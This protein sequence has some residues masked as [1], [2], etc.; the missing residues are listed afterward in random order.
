MDRIYF[1]KKDRKTYPSKTIV[2][3][4]VVTA[5][6][7]T[8]LCLI[9]RWYFFLGKLHANSSTWIL[10]HFL[11]SGDMSLHHHQC[12]MTN[13][14]FGR[15]LLC[16]NVMCLMRQTSNRLHVWKHEKKVLYKK[17]SLSR[18]LNFGIWRQ[19]VFFPKKCRDNWVLKVLGRRE[20]RLPAIRLLADVIFNSQLSQCLKGIL[21]LQFWCAF[22]GCVLNLKFDALKN[23][24]Q[25]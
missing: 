25:I 11:G 4:F 3:I 21:K 20:A 10:W 7:K 16:P 6:T 2:Y 15:Y 14:R 17:P 19:H 8:Y 18:S 12:G 24:K 5:S 13:R 23:D 22:F 1:S 9:T